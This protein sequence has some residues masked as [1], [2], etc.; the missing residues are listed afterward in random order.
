MSI[1]IR[2]GRGV[3]RAKDRALCCAALLAL[4]LMTH[5]R[6][7]SGMEPPQGAVLFQN[8]RIFDGKN[9]ALSAP[10]NV[11]IRGNKIEKISSVPIASGQA[12]GVRVIEGGGRTLMPGLIDAHWHAFMAATPMTT[13]L[14]ADAGYLH[15]L[16]GQQASETLMRGFTSVRDMAGPTFGLKRALDSGVL[17]GPRI[18]PRAQ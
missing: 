14:T 9:S 3:R 18:F 13:M 6:A 7:E 8:V 5:A 2:E 4:G 1:M 17:A 10:E 12:E 15:L 11:L 16:A